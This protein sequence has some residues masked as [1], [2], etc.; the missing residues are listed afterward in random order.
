MLWHI[1]RS[2]GFK[3]S[4]F[5]GVVYPAML[6]VDVNIAKTK[7]MLYL[8]VTDTFEQMS[9]PDEPDVIIPH[10]SPGLIFTGNLESV[11]EYCSKTL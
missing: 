2:P 6:A 8:G 7:K 5:A 10:H 4:I 9:R 3:L 11:L 1:S